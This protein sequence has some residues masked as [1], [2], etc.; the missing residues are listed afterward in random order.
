MADLLMMSKSIIAAEIISLVREP[1][2]SA[3]PLLRSL[4]GEERTSG[5]GAKN[6]E[7]DPSRTFAPVNYRI[8][9][10]MG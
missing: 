7:N 5:Q 2:S 10:P 6:D 4:T 8:A 3:K 9:K 1:L